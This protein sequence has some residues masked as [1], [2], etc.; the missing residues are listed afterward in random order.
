VIGVAKSRLF[1]N[2]QEPPPEQGAYT[3]LYDRQEILGA[4]LRTRADTQPVFVSVGHRIS[5]PQAIEL[6]L[7][8]TTRYRI[9][10]PTR[11]AHLLSKRSIES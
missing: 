10:E 1:G 5:L 7:A 3:Y 9:P 8:C 11:Q 6:T 4:V 2:F